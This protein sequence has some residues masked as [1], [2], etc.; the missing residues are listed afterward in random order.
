MKYWWLLIS[1]GLAGC[2]PSIKDD[3]ARNLAGYAQNVAEDGSR[4]AYG[5]SA[6]ADLLKNRVDE[7]EDRVSRIESERSAANGISE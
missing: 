4:V 1:I 5:A 3:D 2:S 7:M 6:N